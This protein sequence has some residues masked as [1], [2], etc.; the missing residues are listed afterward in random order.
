MKTK[1]LT[2]GLVAALAACNRA[3]TNNLAGNQAAAPPA[4]GNSSG[5]PLPAERSEAQQQTALPAGLDCVRNRMSP[6]QRRAVAQAAMEQAPREDPR[7]QPLVQAVDTCGSELSWSPQKRRLAGM[8]SVSAAGAAGV[9]EE[10][11]GQGVR[12]AELDQLI[13]SDEQLM[14]AAASGQLDSTAGSEFAQRHLE[15]LQR[16]A[17]G[18]SLEGELGTRLGAYVGFRALAESLAA[19]F[20]REP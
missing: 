8:F 6:E 3:P 1:L 17:G 20:G 7:V 10:L 11:S 4:A 2:I 15:E 12:V 16:I 13:L 9:R 18:D 19:R 14:A 5:L